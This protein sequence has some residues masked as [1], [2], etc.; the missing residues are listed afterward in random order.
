MSFGGRGMEAGG[1]PQVTVIRSTE[2]VD[3][4]AKD[5]CPGAEHGIGE[6][7]DP[8]QLAEMHE[9]GTGHF[10]VPDGLGTERFTVSRPPAAVFTDAA[11]Q[12]VAEQFQGWGIL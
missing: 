7:S 4:V 12:L 2:L 5:A 1:R 6:E 10:A 8:S 11:P 3:A 9:D